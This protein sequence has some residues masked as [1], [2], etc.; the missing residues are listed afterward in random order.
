MMILN[1][2]FVLFTSVSQRFIFCYKLIYRITKKRIFAHLKNNTM[3]LQQILTEQIQKAVNELFAI[4]IEKV[5]FQATRKE[6]EGDIT[7]VVFP[8]VKVLK[9]NPVE[10]GTKLGIT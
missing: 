5:E 4:S 7:M 8:L 10:I 3:S 1:M 9:G 6:F 2:H